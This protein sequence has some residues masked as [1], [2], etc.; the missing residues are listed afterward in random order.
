MEHSGLLT[1]NIINI[2]TGKGWVTGGF[3]VPCFGWSPAY[4][5]GLCKEPEG[6]AGHF[7]YFGQT[8][9]FSGEIGVFFL[10]S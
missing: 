8:S 5:S 10:V 4:I 6:L 3:A 2:V 9:V 7:A 1:S